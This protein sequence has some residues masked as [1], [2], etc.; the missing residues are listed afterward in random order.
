MSFLNRTSARPRNGVTAASAFVNPFETAKALSSDSILD[1]FETSEDRLGVFPFVNERYPGWQ[2][3]GVDDVNG[4]TCACSQD[5]ILGE[6]VRVEVKVCE[7]IG[8]TSDSASLNDSG[9]RSSGVC[10]RTLESRCKN[11]SEYNMGSGL[12]IERI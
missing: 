8:M 3:L 9:D 7:E 5:W 2:K 11:L 1:C 12:V 6:E 10:L 4:E